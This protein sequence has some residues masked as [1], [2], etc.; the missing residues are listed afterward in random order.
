M[1]FISLGGNLHS[2]TGSP[3][4]T[5]LAALFELERAGVIIRRCSPWYKTAPVPISDQPWFV[6]GVAEVETHFN[7][8]QLMSLLH[9][10]EEIF[11]RVR[12]ELNGAR[13]L[14]MDLL[15]YHDLVQDAEDGDASSLVLPHPRLH[16]RA[17]VLLP[18]R[19]LAPDWRHPVLG[20][21]V[22][23]LARGL[24]SDQKAERL[25]APGP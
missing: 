20:L 21:T 17:F 6:N 1:I 5:C 8:L 12:F 24:S 2:A 23:E 18:L 16:D 22:S 4:E 14:D 19:D 25:P 10:I 15:A 3:L 13:T 7:P 11:Q 9:E